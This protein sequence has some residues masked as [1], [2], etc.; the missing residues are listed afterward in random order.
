MSK[1]KKQRKKHSA[2][3][4]RLKKRLKC[5]IKEIRNGTAIR[6]TLSTDESVPMVSMVFP[7]HDYWLL[8]FFA[9]GEVRLYDLIWAPEQPCME[10]LKSIDFYKKVH[11]ANGRVYWNKK[12]SL[13]SDLLYNNSTP[14]TDDTGRLLKLL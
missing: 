4:L 6:H 9:N 5:A 12:I 13:D 1:N 8:L 10:K 7:L 14:L 11:V 2:F 3:Y